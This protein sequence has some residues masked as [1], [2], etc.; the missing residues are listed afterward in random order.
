MKIMKKFAIICAAMF[1]FCCIHPLQAHAGTI[2]TVNAAVE[3][4]GVKVTGT[5]ETGVLAVVVQVRDASNNILTMETFSV[6]EGGTF[7]AP[8][9]LSLT[10]G[11]YKVYVADFDGGD[12]STADFTVAASGGGTGGS[13]NG[14]GSGNNQ[15]NTT[16]G[17]GTSSSGSSSSAESKPVEVIVPVKSDK[18]ETTQNKTTEKETQDKKVSY[19][20]AKEQTVTDQLK[21][22][23]GKGTL[24]VSVESTDEQGE[25]Y[26][27]VITGVKISSLENVLRAVMTEEE[28]KEVENGKKVEIKL[29]VENIQQSAPEASKAAIEEMISSKTAEIEGLTLGSYINITLEKKVGNGSW[30]RMSELHEELEITIDIPN[31]LKMDN[32]DYWI[33]RDHEGT[34]SMLE[35]LDNNDATI[36]FRTNAFSTY[37]IAYAVSNVADAEGDS[38]DGLADVSVGALE[39]T[40]TQETGLTWYWW[41]LPVAVL[42]IAIVGY[43]VYKKNSSNEK[44]TK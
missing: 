19:E 40:Q 15:N 5:T 8:I 18:K 20:E 7:E 3:N 26:G 6:K 31:E 44:D 10:A 25:A 9:T 1:I 28:L 33:M 30:S 14:S 37:A 35:D 11:N 42:V 17:T 23:H 22:T 16:T 43:T 36:T 29:S 39:E 4:T 13:G 12:W 32:A 27:N 38:E 34:V 41:L 21:V 24:T 2:S